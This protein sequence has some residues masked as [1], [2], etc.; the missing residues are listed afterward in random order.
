MSA[1]GPRAAL[2]RAVCQRVPRR[3]LQL[4]A[5]SAS[6]QLLDSGDLESAYPDSAHM[7]TDVV[8]EALEGALDKADLGARLRRARRREMSRIAWR[9]LGGVADLDETLR[10]LSAFA[11]AAISESLRHLDALQRT[12]R[13]VPT[14]AEGQP[15]SLVVYALGK[16]GAGELNYSSDV[17]LIFAYPGDGET[18]GARRSISNHEYFVELGRSLIETLQRRS[19]EGFVFRVDMRL[20]PFR[21]RRSPG[22][23]FRG[24]GGLLPAPWPRLGALR[25]DPYA[26]HGRRQGLPGRQL[27]D[28]LTP[29]VFRRYLDFGTLESLREMKAMIAAEV[30]RR[31]LDDHVKLGP[32]GIRELEFT[33]QAFQ[34]VRG[35]RHPR[36]ARTAVSPTCSMNWAGAN[37]CLCTPWKD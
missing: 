12:R 31:E 3:Q 34:L 30:A 9:D 24:H 22:H 18:V 5:R 15:Q 4:Q 17:D 36:I 20:R 35:G 13:G 25:A 19:E 7:R 37:C 23:E 11:D 2:A 29:F 6:P 21:P 1:R 26:P 27:Y 16:L 28:R 8:T 10:D 33:V 32:G 14:D